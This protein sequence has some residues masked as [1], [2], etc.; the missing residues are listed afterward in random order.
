MKQATHW[1]NGRLILHEINGRKELL[2]S[3]KSINAAKKDARAL[4]K[5]GAVLR[6]IR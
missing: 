3:H 1:R 2:R 5:A 4:Q 6:V